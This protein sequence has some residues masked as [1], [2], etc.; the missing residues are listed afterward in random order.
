[1]KALDAAPRPAPR[2]SWKR[3][4]AAKSAS[5]TRRSMIDYVLRGRLSCS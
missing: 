4:R 5:P 3:W 1:M 2:P